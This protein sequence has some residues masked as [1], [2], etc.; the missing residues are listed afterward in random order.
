IV[1][2][3]GVTF[4]VHLMGFVGGSVDEIV[5]AYYVAA[6][7]FCVREKYRNI[8]QLDNVAADVKLGMQLELIRLGRRTTRWIFRHRL[9]ATNVV[10]LVSEFQTKIQALDEYRGQLMGRVRADRWEE[11]VQHLIEAHVPEPLARDAANAADMAIAL[12]VIDAAD[13]TST[14]PVAVA[15]A[16]ATLGRELSLDWLTEHLGNLPSSSQWQAMERDSLLDDV[17]THQGVLAAR[18]IYAEGSDV[19][20]W[21]SEHEHFARSWRNVIEDAQHATVQDFSMFSIACRKLNDLCRTL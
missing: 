12:P 6:E 7:I 11:R 14:E 2:H 21:L 9:S 3:M 4:V 15:Q 5:R 17:T 8:E 18:S 16:Y 13:R 10:E 19:S 1:D 20:I